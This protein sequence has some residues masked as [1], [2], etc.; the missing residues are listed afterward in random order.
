MSR[1][2][3]GGEEEVRGGGGGALFKEVRALICRVQTLVPRRGAILH[4]ASP[5]RLALE[6]L[7]CDSSLFEL[8]QPSFIT[9]GSSPLLLIMGGAGLL[10]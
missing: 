2:E 1:Q 7:A 8:S 3:G 5:Y 4:A 9:P 10:S 6:G